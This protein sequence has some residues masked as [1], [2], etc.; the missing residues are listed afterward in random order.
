MA[1]STPACDPGYRWCP[2]CLTCVTLSA[3]NKGPK[4]PG[5]RAYCRECER[6]WV[7]AR[8]RT[9]GRK[10]KYRRPIGSPGTSWCPA[11][12][13]F[14]D[15]N[16]M[17]RRSDGR[18][19]ICRPCAAARAV[20]RKGGY[21]TGP[22]GSYNQIPKTT[23]YRRCRSCKETKPLSEFFRQGRTW[24]SWCKPCDTQRFKTNY[25]E[26]VKRGKRA[27]W[28]RLAESVFAAYGQ[29]CVCCDT[30]VR[31]FLTIDHIEGRGAEHLRA[32]GKGKKSAGSEKFYKWLVKNNFPPGFQTLCR[33]C[34]WAKH[35]LGSLAL[36]PHR[37]TPAQH[38][39]E[40]PSAG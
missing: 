7:E 36:C 6:R 22:R 1:R 14:A 23:G 3:F 38:T 34:N 10:P 4:P 25:Y 27:A 40:P 21:K 9:Q 17:V 32:L 16:T 39:P 28:R 19:T 33:N 30:S 12:K 2:R 29:A 5:V 31:V 24:K 8:R 11:A 35:V 15:I 26:A 37:A 18:L 20:K 13:H